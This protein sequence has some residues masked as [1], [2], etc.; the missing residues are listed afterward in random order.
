MTDC[1]DRSLVTDG[2]PH[3]K[4]V[5]FDGV[6]VAAGMPPPEVRITEDV[7]S[8]NCSGN[9]SYKKLEIS[10]EGE[11]ACCSAQEKIAVREELLELFSSSCGDLEACGE[12]WENCRVTGI[13]ISPV[14][15]THL[16]AH[17]T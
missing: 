11:L 14:S 10:L 5:F 7:S 6:E 16:R 13:D 15:Y 1:I 17:E 8:G 2:I 3:G 12:T 9:G 4:K